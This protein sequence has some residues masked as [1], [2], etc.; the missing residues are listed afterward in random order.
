MLKNIIEQY[1]GVNFDMPVALV[2]SG[3][4][5]A[6]RAFIANTPELWGGRTDLP[7]YSLGCAIGAHI[8]PG[9]YGLAFFQR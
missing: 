7:C 1:G 6:L 9:A 5:E 8:G 2:Y 3:T 4:D